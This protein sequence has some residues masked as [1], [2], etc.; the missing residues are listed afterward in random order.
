MCLFYCCVYNYTLSLPNFKLFESSYSAFLKLTLIFLNWYFRFGRL[1][2]TPFLSKCS[3]CG[4]VCIY[5]CCV[6]VFTYEL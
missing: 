1:K 6:H 3:Y 4:G 2:E 5:I